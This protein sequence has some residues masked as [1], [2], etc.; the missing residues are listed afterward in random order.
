M[1]LNKAE[2]D[3]A[4]IAIAS[5]RREGIEELRQKGG[6]AVFVLVLVVRRPSS[7]HRGFVVLRKPFSLLLVRGF[8]LGPTGVSPT[9]E[10]S[11]VDDSLGPLGV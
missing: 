3:E 1:I 9:T 4:A 11:F 8:E 6:E 2:D 5:P 10:P 7:H